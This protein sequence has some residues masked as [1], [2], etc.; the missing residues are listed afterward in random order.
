MFVEKFGYWLLRIE[1]TNET[2]FDVMDNFAIFLL[3]EEKEKIFY[4]TPFF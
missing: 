3:Y 4:C 2:L 1:K